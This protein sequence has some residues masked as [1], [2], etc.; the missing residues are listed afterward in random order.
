M[1]CILSVAALLATH[2]VCVPNELRLS[3]MRG[4]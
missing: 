3:F 4:G 2:L 1:Q